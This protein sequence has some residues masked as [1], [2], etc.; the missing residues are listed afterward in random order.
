M[1]ISIF[2]S[3]KKAFCQKKSLRTIQYCMISHL[4]KGPLRKIKSILHQDNLKNIQFTKSIKTHQNFMLELMLECFKQHDKN[5]THSSISSMGIT[6]KRNIVHYDLPV[7]TFDVKTSGSTGEPFS[8]KIWRDCYRPIEI[9]NHYRQVLQEFNI[10]E[11]PN[12]LRVGVKSPK[13]DPKHARQHEKITFNGCT[14]FSRTFK[15]NQMQWK[16]SHGSKD[17]TCFHFLYDQED[18]EAFCLFIVKFLKYNK[19]DVFLTSFSFFSILLSYMDDSTNICNLLSNTGEGPVEEEVSFALNAGIIDN[20]CNH[21]RSW[22]GGCTFMTCKYGELHLLDYLAYYEDVDDKIVSTDFFNIGTPFFRY[23]N[24][25][26]CSINKKW[27][28][29]KCGRYFRKAKFEGRNSFV[30]NNI[31]SIEILDAIPYLNCMCQ[32]K[33]FKDYLEISTSLEISEEVKNNIRS[34]LKNVQ[35]SLDNFFIRNEKI[36]RIIDLRLL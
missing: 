24:G 33:C 34:N 12:I 3:Q 28:I 32:I 22:D 20:F 14:F 6:N 13:F 8:Y 4:P 30:W 25:D 36:A 27:E 1:M 29:C 17:S 5:F 31:P 10:S 9:D 23:W 11:S 16:L 15:P 2:C 21:M 7:S 35:F 26:R 18:V 19:M